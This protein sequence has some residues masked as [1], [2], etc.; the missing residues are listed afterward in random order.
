MS[1]LNNNALQFVTLDFVKSHFK[2]TDK[3]DDD[4][5]LGIVQAA[6]LEVKKQIR[7]VVDDIDAIEG[8]RFFQEAQTA[9]LTFVEAE[10]RR[11][12]NQLYTEADT[13]MA[14]F[15]AKMLTL[16]GDIR[17]EAPTRK[18]RNIASRD[19]DFEDEF[20]STRRTV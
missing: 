8:S 6:N 15:T 13:I 14:Q 17:S 4:T 16:V 9:A 10:I 1:L 20:F 18:S 7:P 12:I 11:Q 2:I 19:E 5:L 3:Q